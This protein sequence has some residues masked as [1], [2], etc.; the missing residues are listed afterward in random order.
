MATAALDLDI[1]NL[2]P[3]ITL[4]EHY[5]RAFILIRLPAEGPWGRLPVKVAVWLDLISASHLKIGIC[6]RIINCLIHRTKSFF[7]P[8][9]KPRHQHQ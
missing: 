8:F 3:E 6:A 1:E 4:P 5:Q 2:P 9:T 7:N